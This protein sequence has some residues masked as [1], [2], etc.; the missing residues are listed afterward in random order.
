MGASVVVGSVIVNKVEKDRL[1]VCPYAEQIAVRFGVPLCLCSLGFGACPS[2]GR[3]A[4]FKF[5]FTG[6]EVVW[7]CDRLDGFPDLER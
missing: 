6:F 7:V 2:H 3:R 5:H 4:K 1:A